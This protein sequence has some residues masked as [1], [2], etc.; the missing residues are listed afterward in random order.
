VEI[1]RFIWTEHAERRLGQR[2]LTRLD[3]EAVVRDGHDSREINRGDADW[4]VYGARSDGRRFAVIYD[5]PA[6]ADAGL[7]RIVSV[8]PLREPSQS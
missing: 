1:E 3:V 2:G 8:W 6:Q 7:A 4:R 5:H